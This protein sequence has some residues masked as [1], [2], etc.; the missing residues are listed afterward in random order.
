MEEQWPLSLPQEQKSTNVTFVKNEFQSGYFLLSSY[1]QYHK[2]RSF[3]P[4]DKDIKG[5]TKIDRCERGVGDIEKES[6]KKTERGGIYI[7]VHI[8]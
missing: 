1:H 4:K 5:R 7:Y 8:L 6:D 2:L 3:R